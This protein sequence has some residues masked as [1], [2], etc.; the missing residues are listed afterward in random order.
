M[1]DVAIVGAGGAGTALLDAIAPLPLR[2]VVVDPVRDKGND[3]TWCFWSAAPTPVDGIAHRVWTR[4]QVGGHPLEL[5]PFRY[6]MVRSGD[7]YARAGARADAEWITESATVRD[8][9]EAAEVVAGDRRLTARW[10][11]DSRPF[12]PARRVTLLWQH[13]AGAVVD[14][15]YDA[16]DPD[17][18][19][20]MDFA[21][22][23]PPD[24]LAFR[25]SLPLTARRALVEYTVFGRERYPVDA[26][27][28]A[29]LPAGHRVVETERGA[30]PM[31][32]GRF[33]RRV[34]RRVFRIGTAGGATRGATGYTFAAM[35]R[36]AAAIA[37]AL[38]HNRTP[39]PPPPYPRRHRLADAALLRAVDRNLVDGPGF[40]TDFLTGQPI[41]RALRFLDGDTSVVEDLAVL[42]GTP[43]PAMLR[44]TAGYLSAA[45]RRRV[46]W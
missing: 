10:V 25:Y 21:V 17:V 6:L 20:L 45:A 40:F 1:Y 44:A 46:G 2:V 36:Q 30:I 31:T 27:L 23:Q 14:T 29:C 41:E 33:P 12:L 4:A 37:D 3:R 16:F 18:A 13:F 43:I 5:A 39:V 32:D 22:P 11:F 26:E 28:A 8:G 38:A 24:G 34:G 35:L 9:R 42:A 15:P 19:T 7:F